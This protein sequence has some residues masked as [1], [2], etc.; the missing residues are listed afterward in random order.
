MKRKLAVVR[1]PQKKVSAPSRLLLTELRELILS[2]R[3]TVARGV[4]TALVGLYWKIGERI[5]RDILREKRA[6][7]GEQI[8]AALSQ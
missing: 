3:Q 4:N 6:G 1:T 8:V 2:T 5:H 7:Y